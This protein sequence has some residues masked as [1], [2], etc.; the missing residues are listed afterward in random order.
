MQ[1]QNIPLSLSAG[2][3]L[4][5]IFLVG[6]L[7]FRIEKYVEAPKSGAPKKLALWV[8]ITLSLYLALVLL[9]T[10]PELGLPVETTYIFLSFFSLSVV[11]WLALNKG[12]QSIA[13][14]F[15]VSILVWLQ[16]FR[17]FQE[18]IFYLLGAEGLL[19]AQM[20]FAGLQ[21][22]IHLGVASLFVGA[23]VAT[24]AKP[25]KT[26]L[27]IWNSLGIV[28]IVWNYYLFVAS[29]PGPLQAFQELPL[30]RMGFTVPFIWVPCFTY[31]LA[32]L[33]H[34]SVL[35][36]LLKASSKNHSPR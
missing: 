4:L 24:E 2:F 14:S 19:P 23:M 18:V 10:Y 1:S 11:A 26:A 13:S 17:V 20:S 36:E 5:V 29:S 28:S 7:I 9:A 25:A 30:N 15:S 12:W 8:R 33:L 31:P 32:L 21:F 22:D 3:V 6:F 34:L 27:W 35:R 16:F